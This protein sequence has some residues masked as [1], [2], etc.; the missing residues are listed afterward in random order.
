[1]KTGGGCKDM[2]HLQGLGFSMEER[3]LISVFSGG[4]RTDVIS[5]I[6]RVM[7]HLE[8]DMLLGLS[9]RVLERL[10][11]ISDEEFAGLEFMGQR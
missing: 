2:N 8:D 11:H 7:P 5:D 4:S 9:K 6:N 10:E 1:M 3:S